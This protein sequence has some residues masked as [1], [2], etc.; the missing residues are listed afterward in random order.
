MTDY[1]NALL[2]GNNRAKTATGN[3]A[4]RYRPCI[5][6]SFRPHF[7]FFGVKLRFEFR[8]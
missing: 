5:A 7:S 8:L 1:L 3:A 4:N 6:R 2:H